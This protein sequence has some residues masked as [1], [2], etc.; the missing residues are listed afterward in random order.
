MTKRMRVALEAETSRVEVSCRFDFYEC[1]RHLCCFSRFYSPFRCS[2][3][4]VISRFLVTPR[5]SK[6]DLAYWVALKRKSD[7]YG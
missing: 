4:V 7:F 5:V 6:P 1:Y 2:R 3:F